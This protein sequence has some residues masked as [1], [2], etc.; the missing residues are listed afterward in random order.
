MQALLP[1]VLAGVEAARG[2]RELLQVQLGQ[3]VQ[4][5]AGSAL[6]PQA[7]PQLAVLVVALDQT[8]LQ[9]RRLP[10]SRATEAPG[11]GAEAA[12]MC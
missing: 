8:L 6:P 11:V 3:T 9:P 2:Q 1:P 12:L 7:A 10:Y 5:V 4:G